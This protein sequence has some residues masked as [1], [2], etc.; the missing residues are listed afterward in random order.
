M[1]EIYD[2]IEIVA[3]DLYWRALKDIPDDVRAGVRSG[4]ANEKKDGKPD[5]RSMND[6][7]KGQVTGPLGRPDALQIFRLEVK[8]PVREIPLRFRL[9]SSIDGRPSETT[10]V[11]H[12]TA[13]KL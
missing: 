4:L 2:T 13:K 5:L 7:L 6:E 12:V 10:F 3:R 11:A 9:V 8:E 1:L